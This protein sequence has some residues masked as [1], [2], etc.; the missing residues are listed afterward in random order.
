MRGET[1]AQRHV[2]K[3]REQRDVYELTE[4]R[5]LQQACK[6]AC[7]HDGAAEAGDLLDSYTRLRDFLT[8]RIREN[9][10]AGLARYIALAQDSYREGLAA[11][12][13]ALQIHLALEDVDIDKLKRELSAWRGRIDNASAGDRDI[14]NR[15][16]DAHERRLDT[17][18]RSVQAI[19]EL[20]AQSNEQ[21]SALEN[22]LLELSGLVGD[23][24]PSRAG[25]L[26]SAN[27]LEIA[28]KAARRVEEKM[29][30]IGASKTTP[31]DEEY[32][33]AGQHQ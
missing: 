28:I 25:D 14:L 16:I 3:L 20:I 32:L 30:N 27:R 21:E 5:D 23:D 26:E 22:A 2:A 18:E 6:E 15:Q 7:F 8:E 13:L 19:A 24:I 10:E 1:L 31:E 12:H 17:Y 11:L 29:R 33:R 4:C 9:G